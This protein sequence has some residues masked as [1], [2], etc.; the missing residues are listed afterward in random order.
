MNFDN[1]K[2]RCSSIGAIM[3]NQPGKKD[4]KT[5]DE[6]SATAIKELIKIYVH[7]VYGRDKEISSKYIQKGLECEEDSITLLSRVY[8]IPFFKNEKRVDNDYITGEADITDPRLM[9]TKS[10]WDLHTFFE[11]K[12]KK[13]DRGYEYQMLGYTE[14]YGFDVGSVCFCLIDTPLGLIEDEKNKLFYRMN[15]ATRENPVYLAACEQLEKELTFSDIPLKDRLFEVRVKRNPAEMERVY[16]RVRI[17]RQWLNDF[18][19]KE[20]KVKHLIYA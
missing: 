16:E 10:C 9:D 12:T 19:E 8:M 13:L 14:L 2:I 4:T 18:A 5:V 3:T 7:E 15:V 20:E 6:L 11:H 1:I 17:C